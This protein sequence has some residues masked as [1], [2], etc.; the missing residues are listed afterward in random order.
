MET[1]A[2]VFKNLHGIPSWNVHR[3]YGTFLTMEFGKPHLEIR[4]PIESKASSKRVRDHF[5][6]R[7]VTVRGDWHLWIY[8]C[9]WKVFEESRL[10]GDCTSNRRIDRAAHLLDGQAL[11]NVESTSRGTRWVFTFDLGARLETRPYNRISEQWLLYEPKGKC[12]CVSANGRFSYGPANQSPDK[13]R[14]RP[15]A[16][17][18]RA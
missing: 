7:M 15:I 16:P 14:W 11:V 6:R 12:L 17:R 13:E 8:C 4:E 2:A 18:K 1:I 3:G 10:V 5:A 9:R